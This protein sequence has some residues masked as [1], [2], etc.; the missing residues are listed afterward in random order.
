MSASDPNRGD[1]DSELILFQQPDPASNHNAGD[2]HFGPD[3][4]PLH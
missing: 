3:D 4:L 1:P 2:L